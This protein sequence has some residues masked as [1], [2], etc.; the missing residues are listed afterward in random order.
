MQYLLCVDLNRCV[1]CHACEVACSQEKGFSPYDCEIKVVETEPQEINGKLYIY[2]IPVTTN[3]CEFCYS[4][5][6]QGV[7]P[8]CEASCP[9]KAIRCAIAD[10]LVESIAKMKQVSML[11]LAEL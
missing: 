5:I 10:E 1:G 11:K 4:L 9:T 7:S 2:F 6:S 3:K 8:A